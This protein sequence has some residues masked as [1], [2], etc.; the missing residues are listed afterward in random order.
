MSKSAI[1]TRAPCGLR[2]GSPVF[3]STTF[4]RTAAHKPIGNGFNVDAT[5]TVHGAPAFSCAGMSLKAVSA[6]TP[7]RA[8]RI[9]CFVIFIAA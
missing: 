2:G 9:E 5:V 3:G 1:V 8:E 7:N 6:K 4:S